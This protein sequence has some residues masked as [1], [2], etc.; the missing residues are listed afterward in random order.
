LPYLIKSGGATGRRWP[1][2]SAG[3]GLAEARPARAGPHEVRQ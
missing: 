2:T 3:L 1:G